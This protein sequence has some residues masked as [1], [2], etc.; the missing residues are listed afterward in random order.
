MAF[1]IENEPMLA[2]SKYQAGDPTGWI[3]AR[4]AHMRDEL[5][6]DNPI[7]IVSGGVGGTYDNGAND[8]PWVTSCPCV[9]IVSIQYYDNGD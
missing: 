3:C 8:A 7:K 5:G 9:D 4:A 6:A 1:D 2:E